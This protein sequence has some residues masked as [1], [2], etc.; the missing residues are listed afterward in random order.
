MDLIRTVN[1]E[2]SFYN[3]NNINYQKLTSQINK[4][5]VAKLFDTSFN[6]YFVI[7]V[8]QFTPTNEAFIIIFTSII[9]NI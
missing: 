7:F 4:D 5:N 1:I 2:T 3:N 8:N 9:F 6:E